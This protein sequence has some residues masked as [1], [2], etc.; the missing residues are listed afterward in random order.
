MK[1][2]LLKN[3]LRKILIHQV[4]VISIILLSVLFFNKAQAQ[5]AKN[6][7]YID[8]NCPIYRIDSYYDQSGFVN[9]SVLFSEANGDTLVN[10]NQ[11]NNVSLEGT[12]KFKSSPSIPIILP[13]TQGDSNHFLFTS[14][15]CYGSGSNRLCLK[16]KWKQIDNI[17]I[18]FSIN[19]SRLHSPYYKLIPADIKGANVR[20]SIDFLKDG[21][22]FFDDS[23]GIISLGITPHTISN[24]DSIKITRRSNTSEEIIDKEVLN[25]PKSSNG[26]FT[27]PLKLHNNQ[28]F[29]ADS[30]YQYFIEVGFS[31]LSNGSSPFDTVITIKVPILFQPKLKIDNFLVNSNIK[32]VEGFSINVHREDTFAVEIIT[33]GIGN[34]GIKSVPIDFCKMQINKELRSDNT[35]LL[36]L[37]GLSTLK[38]E[39][40][41]AYLYFTTSDGTILN[42][43]PCTF[44]KDAHVEV[45]NLGLDVSKRNN[46]L[47]IAFSLPDWYNGKVSAS[48]QNGKVSINDIERNKQSG[49]YSET[50]TPEAFSIIKN[51]VKQDTII[52]DTINIL[53]DGKNIFKV[54][55]SFLNQNILDSLEHKLFLE[56]NKKK[57]DPKV[58]SSTVNDIAKVVNKKGGSVVGEDEKQTV[59]KNLSQTHKSDTD[60]TNS[61]L[62]TMATIG[63]WVA[64][65]APKVVPLFI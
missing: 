21:L 13:L 29:S 30:K 7:R 51:K 8:K 37:S 28:T 48:L 18:N 26:E 53:A 63:S 52:N 49:L 35:Y 33:S 34:L 19:G 32:P 59:I 3:N 55:V 64:K 44:T 58:I 65:V 22:Y 54:S 60:K 2:L 38:N 31:T 6:Q 27:L 61:T 47:V 24:I 14:M 15:L 40:L 43:K 20:P 16:D 23:T 25:I 11:L 5:N 62:S 41:N 46:N 12:V 45:A 36:K 10:L 57:P 9:I 17:K 56:A 42:T 1:T 4:R 50:F 39:E